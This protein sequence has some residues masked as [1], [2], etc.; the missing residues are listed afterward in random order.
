MRKY[1]RGV[2]EMKR[3]FALCLVSGG[4]AGSFLKE[5]PADYNRDGDVNMQDAGALYAIAEG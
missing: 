5:E 1:E 4:N 3:W 2:S